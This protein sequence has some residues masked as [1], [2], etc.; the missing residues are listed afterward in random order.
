MP[1]NRESV[2]A[3]RRHKRRVD[4]GYQTPFQ[5]YSTPSYLTLDKQ[6]NFVAKE[7]EI[8]SKIDLNM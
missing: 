3:D 5:A 6:D 2:F 7:H 1:L 4:A 8:F